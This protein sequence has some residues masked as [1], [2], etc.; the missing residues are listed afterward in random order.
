MAPILKALMSSGSKK[1]EPRHT[2]L[3]EAK[4]AHSQRCGPRFHH[5][6]HTSY[7]FSQVVSSSKEAINGPGLCLVKYNS[8][9]LAVGLGSGI[10]SRACL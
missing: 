1:K 3:S 7:V 10:N 8:R 6:L 4:S 9:V 5:L 2:C